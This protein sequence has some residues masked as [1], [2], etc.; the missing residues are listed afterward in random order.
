MV[1][2][3]GSKLM[4]AQVDPGP[5][6]NSIPISKYKTLFPAH[7]MKAGNLNRRHFNQQDTPGQLITTPCNSSIGFFISD[8]Y[9]KTQP[10][11]QQVRFDVL[12]DTTCP[13][14]LLSY[15]ASERLGIVKFQVSSKTP[16]TALDTITSSSKHF[17]FRT[18]MQMDTPVKPQ[19]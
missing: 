6:I 4:P 2:K 18:P 17:L 7:F 16:L 5:D 14:I 19:Q 1:N 9:H 8:N 10:E 12:K 3:H 15:T 13:K 11:V